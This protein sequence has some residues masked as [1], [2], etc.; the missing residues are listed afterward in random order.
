MKYRPLTDLQRR[1]LAML[2]RLLPKP[3]NGV[4]RSLR[5]RGLILLNKDGSYSFSDEGWYQRANVLR[6]AFT[7]LRSANATAF[8]T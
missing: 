3:H 7:A 2:P 1:A 5:M 4:Y 8:L 6:Q